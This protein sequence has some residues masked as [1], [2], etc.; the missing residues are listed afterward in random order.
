MGP[1][2]WLVSNSNC[3]FFG[4]PF[5]VIVGWIALIDFKISTTHCSPNFEIDF[6]VQRKSIFTEHYGLGGNPPLLLRLI[7]ID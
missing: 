2:K 1:L 3:L 6:L 7:S 5:S 4:R